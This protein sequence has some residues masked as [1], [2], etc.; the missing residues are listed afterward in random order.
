MFNSI[1]QSFKINLKMEIGQVKK[2]RK[3]PPPSNAF[4]QLYFEVSWLVFPWLDRRD[5]LRGEHS[6]LE[7]TWGEKSATRL[8]WEKQWWI[9]FCLIRTDQVR[10]F[11]Y[12]LNFIWNCSMCSCSCSNKT[13]SINIVRPSFGM[14]G[15]FDR[16]IFKGLFD[17]SDMVLGLRLDICLV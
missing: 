6:T 17:G 16:N 8:S 14:W 1:I 11:L 15:H 10:H 5:C 9:R 7:V 2:Y 4:T 3:K 13:Y 12:W